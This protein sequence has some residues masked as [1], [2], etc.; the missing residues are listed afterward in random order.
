MNLMQLHP[1]T[2]GFLVLCLA[3]Y[4]TLA[5]LLAY[6]AFA[7]DKKRARRGEWRVPERTLLMLAMLGGWLGA[8]LGQHRLRH[9]TRKQPFRAM[10]N[11]AGLVLPGAIGASLLLS[12]SPETVRGLNMMAADWLG[13][14]RPD[15]AQTA[16]KPVMPHRFGPGS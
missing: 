1:G 8:K 12:A 7:L 2:P 16:D 3:G 10:L 6:A 14:L 11:L 9:K 13:S 4:L 5:N 15:A